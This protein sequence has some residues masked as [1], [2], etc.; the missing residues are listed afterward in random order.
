MGVLNDDSPKIL[1]QNRPAQHRRAV[2]FCADDRYVPFT[3]FLAAQIAAAH[4]D[5]NF[6]LCVV[7]QDRLN[8]HPL[9]DTLN[10]RIVQVETTKLAEHANIGE[11]LGMA[12]YLRLF[13]PRLWQLDY[14]RLLY[15]D[16]D[17]FY[18]RGDVS[19]LLDAPLRDAPLA[20]VLDTKQWHKPHRP[21]AD[22][23]ALNLPFAPYFNGG[24]LLIDVARY[25]TLGIAER[26]IDLI[27]QLGQKLVWHDQTAINA[28]LGGNWAQLPV[29]WNFQYSHK[30]M[31]LSAHFDVCFFHFIGRRKPFYAPYGGFPRRFTVP[32]RQFLRAYFPAL[33]AHVSD[34]GSARQRFWALGLIFLFN[35]TFMRGALRMEA[36]ALDDLDIIAPQP[37]KTQGG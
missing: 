21:A 25:N 14:D 7:S 23:A 27:L 16:G 15:L 1:W 5:R 24:V 20:A 35:L 10:L 3:L 22:I 26:C 32:Y 8:P 34:G 30:T 31:L 17:I 19:A 28:A 13:M 33:A 29:Q 12:T 18:Q 2:F 4:P 36:A 6:D 37:A 11:R 9:F